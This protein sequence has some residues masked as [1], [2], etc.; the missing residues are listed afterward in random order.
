M[1]HSYSKLPLDKKV[2]QLEKKRKKNETNWINSLLTKG[3]GMGR[4]KATSQQNLD[5]I[6]FLRR[7]KT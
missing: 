2:L 5:S 1:N 3:N 4:Y 7:H 6:I